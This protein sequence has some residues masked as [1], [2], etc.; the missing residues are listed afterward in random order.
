M[1]RVG[2]LLM[3]MGG[4]R[5][6]E[7]VEP[8]IQRLFAD[9]N[10]VR[11]PLPVSFFQKPL[12]HWVA[13]RRAPEVRRQYQSIGGGSPNNRTT[14]AQAAALQERLNGP[15]SGESATEYR[16]FAAM[17]YT[18]PSTAEALQMA[19]D[20]GCEQILAISLFP[21]YSTASTGASMSDLQRA[22]GSTAIKETSLQV[23]DR[24]GVNNLY[25]DALAQRCGNSLDAARAAHTHAPHLV[26][27]A[28]GIPLSYLKRGDPYLREIQASV[29]GLMSRLPKDQAFTL[30]FQSRATP[31][32]WV[33]PATEQSL[34]MLGQGGH[35]NLV[36]LP[37]SFVNDHIETLYE[38]DQL[39]ADIAT[40]SGV[41]HYARVPAF[42]ADP[43][44]IGI[45]ENLVKNH[46]AKL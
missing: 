21:H 34:R 45:L 30:C 26:I 9:R 7:E 33:Q 3:Q 4:P 28:H 5:H 15:T 17:T 11:L 39:L 31:V 23:I 19:L 46:E 36:V 12:S 13:R 20:Q 32:K 27:S 29:A 24:W 35:R 16:C 44:L 40:S 14:I 42:N 1:A 38:I 41:E 37:I 43:D 18:P 8:Y 6:L 25:L 10:L 2:I 22:C